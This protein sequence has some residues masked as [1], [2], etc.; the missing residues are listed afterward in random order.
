MKNKN[1][2]LAIILVFLIIA[3][4]GASLY[5]SAK[6]NSDQAVTL[7]APGQSQASACIEKCPAPNGELW[8]CHPKDADG[9]AQKSLCN[10]RGRVEK[11]GSDNYCCPAPGGTWTKDMTKC[12]D[13]PTATLTSTPDPTWVGSTA[14]TVTG[15]VV[16]ACVPDG[17]IT[18]T[19]GCPTACG[20]AAS[21]ITTCKDSCGNAA[22]RQCTT[23]TACDTADVSITKTAYKDE[24]GN[25]AGVYTLTKQIDTISDGQTF[26]YAITIKNDGKAVAN[27]IVVT[28][29]LTGQNQNILTEVDQESR[30]T[31]NTGNRTLTCAGLSLAPGVST[32]LT[33]RVK[34][35]GTTTNGMVIK[36]IATETYNG[37]SKTAEK[38]L[39]ISSVVS[40]NLACTTDAECSDG[41]KCDTTTSMCRKE[42]CLGQSDCSCPSTITPT[43]TVTS[44][45]TG[46][47]TTL[48]VCNKS[49]NVDSDCVA[50]LICDNATAMCRKANCVSAENCSCVTTTTKTQ[51]QATLP[52]TGILDI[53]GVA[54]FGGGLLLVI[55]GILLAL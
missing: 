42:A 25:T 50:G 47:K 49:C 31:F 19:P 27:N 1:K 41:L 14:C 6:I 38:D 15:A 9:S 5:I 39:T 7:N 36:N 21:T 24:D 3:L 35:T 17:T 44:T 55:V 48:A 28:D 18:C 33:F 43:A 8:N 16:V 54:A 52:E 26:I 22:T 29:P 13:S 45:P 51:N 2:V 30:C 4:G 40:C 11:C 34:V 20:T 37:V 23:T 12:P 53:P 10:R 32:T 46:S